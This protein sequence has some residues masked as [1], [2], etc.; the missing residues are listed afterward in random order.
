[1]DRLLL[2]DALTQLKKMAE[3][4][5]DNFAL[6]QEISQF[7]SL[8][9]EAMQLYPGRPDIVGLQLYSRS[10]GGGYGV[11]LRIFRDAVDRLASAIQLRPTGSLGELFSQIVL[12][13]NVAEELR[14]DLTELEGAVGL[15]SW[16]SALLLSGS[17]AEDL[18]LTRHSEQSD[19]GPGIAKLVAQAKE[20]KLFG[21]DILRHLDSLVDYRDLIHPRARIRNKITPNQAR[22]EAALTALKLL[23]SELED[24][25][26]IY[27]P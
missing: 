2:N 20:E 15:G 7:N 16:K 3:G 4:R 12:P 6:E 24:E 17:I 10:A 21:R 14:Q 1:M 9:F 5:T 18:L 13:P 11:S 23:C 22:V 19:R 27:G 25:A 26:A 8:L